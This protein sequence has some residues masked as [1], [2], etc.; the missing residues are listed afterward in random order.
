MVNSHDL[1]AIQEL[2]GHAKLSTTQI[3]TKLDNQEVL[4]AFNAAHPGAKKSRK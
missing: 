2:L 4:K 3:Y 1:R